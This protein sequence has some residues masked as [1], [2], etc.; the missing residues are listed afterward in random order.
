MTMLLRTYTPGPPLDEYIDR[1]WLC[2]DTPPHPRERILPNGTV[3][4]VINLS[5]DEIRIFDASDPARP[6]RYSGAAVAGPYSNFFLIDPLVQASIIGVYFRPG[7]AIPVLGVPVSDLADAHVD[8]ESVWGRTAAEMRER[9][10]TAATPAKRFAVLEEMLLG[11]LRRAP[12]WHGAIPVALDALEQADVAVKVRDLAGRVGLSQRRFIQLFT[13]E[14]GLTP[15]LYGRVRRFQQVRELVRKGTEPDWAAVAAA[16]GFFDQSHLIRDFQ[17]F[18]GLSPVAY[19]NQM[20]KHVLL[21]HVP[22]V[23]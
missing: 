11:R 4:L 5:D 2:S 13:A 10:C 8:L 21:N 15:K 3:Q 20:T 14:V 19:V 9:L 18:S 1:F 17:E 23:G 6:R 7:R 22:W 12:P 16:C